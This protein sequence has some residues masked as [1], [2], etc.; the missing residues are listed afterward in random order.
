MFSRLFSCYISIHAP[1][2]GATARIP[3]C[4][5]PKRISIHA[6]ARGATSGISPFSTA[7]KFQSTHP[8]G[9]RRRACHC[10]NLDHY[11]FNP[12]TR[13]GCDEEGAQRLKEDIEFQST[14]PRGVRQQIGTKTCVNLHFY[15]TSFHKTMSN[16]SPLSA[17]F[18]FSPAI[19]GHFLVRT[20]RQIPVRLGFAPKPPL[21]PALHPDAKERLADIS[22]ASRSSLNCVGWGWG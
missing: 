14:H 1:A 22:S 17:V 4:R 19:C 10:G 20:S 16:Q 8:R 2:R 7:S 15:Y 5:Q 3:N 12:R 21:L 18:S 9:V 6:P 13:A 11:H